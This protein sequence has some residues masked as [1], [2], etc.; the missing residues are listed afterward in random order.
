M[1]NPTS[2]LTR[3]RIELEEFDF[4]VVHIKGK[5]NVA[6]DALSR[7]VTTSE[8]LRQSN[9]LLVNTRSMTRKKAQLKK[10]LGKIQE[11]IK[12]V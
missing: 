12:R 11:E 4:D 3:I 7:I 9:I 1:K 10:I 2:K 8:E 6:A 5:K